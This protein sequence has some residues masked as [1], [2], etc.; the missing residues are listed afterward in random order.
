MVTTRPHGLISCRR[1]AAGSFLR[2]FSGTLELMP[3]AT[4]VPFLAPDPNDRF[5]VVPQKDGIVHYYHG[6]SEW[7]SKHVEQNGFLLQHSLLSDEECR[8]IRTH[9]KLLPFVE[10]YALDCLCSGYRLSLTRHSLEALKHAS[11]SEE[12]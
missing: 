6:T 3:S 1:H 11:R 5:F 12:H 8:A 9:S 4:D 2:P 10:S 7:F